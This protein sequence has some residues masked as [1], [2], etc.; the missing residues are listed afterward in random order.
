MENN[1]LKYIPQRPPFVMVDE[2]LFCDDKQT[3]TSFYITKENILNEGEHF[4]EIGI[5]ENIAQTCAVRL[6]YLNQGKPVKIGMIGAI[7]DFTIFFIPKIEK[8]IET[9]IVLEEEIFNVILLK[10]DVKCNGIPV[11]I[12]KMKVVLTDIDTIT[13]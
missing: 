4:S 3:I 5:I 9:E 13:E 11:A 6:G 8:N 10:A 2:L 12:C 7:N 1:I